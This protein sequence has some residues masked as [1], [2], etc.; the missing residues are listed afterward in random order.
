MKEPHE[1][2]QEARASAGFDEASLAAR[3]LG[4]KEPT[5]L[6]HENG[7]R[8]FRS[9]AD[10]Y[11]R[12]YGVSLEWLLTGRGPRDRRPEPR[13]AKRTVPLVGYVGAGAEAHFMAAGEL[14]EV[15]APDGSSDSTVAVEIRGES[16]GPLFDRWI[17]FYD[18][19]RRPVTAD[20]VGRLCVVG[21]DDGRVM[22]KKIRRS[23]SRGLFHL[24][25]N[26]EAPILDVAIEWAALVKN[27]VP[28]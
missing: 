28:R 6:G 4:I 26:I 13:T 15:E 3:A 1:R 14:G 27:M 8:G 2:L 10:Q 21:L 18:D 20:L 23:K 9:R 19:V 12:K 16:L 7:S 22:V 5:Y 17:V 25:S 11:A 24:I